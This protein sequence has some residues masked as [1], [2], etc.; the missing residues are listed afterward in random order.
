M[1]NNEISPLIDDVEMGG[2]ADEQPLELTLEGSQPSGETAE[3]TLFKTQLNQ[4]LDKRRPQAYWRFL[5][6][7]TEKHGQGLFIAYYMS[8]IVFVFTLIVLL[9]YSA[10]VYN[11]GVRESDDAK[12]RTGIN[13]LLG[14]GVLT[15]V[16]LAFM[17]QGL[18][19]SLQAEHK[20]G[21]M[22]L[23]DVEAHFEALSAEINAIDP[24]QFSSEKFDSTLYE[25]YLSGKFSDMPTSLFYHRVN[26]MKASISE[27][28]IAPRPQ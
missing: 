25:S 12:R 16:L 11:Q 6:R 15:S 22:I 24:L 20:F 4:Q 19:V 28:A 18:K 14:F 9:P 17:M 23:S 27:S 8:V 21:G 10:G 3:L 7:M 13:L 2:V 1:K 5:L 26:K